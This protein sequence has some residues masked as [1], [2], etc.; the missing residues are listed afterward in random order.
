MTS[1]P[2]PIAKAHL[3]GLTPP[4]LAA[5]C[6][7]VLLEPRLARR[8]L[9]RVVGSYRDTLDG[10]P[11]LSKPVVAALE[12]HTRL[13]RL[14]L[15][16]VRASA[17]DPFAKFLFEAEDG[18][19]FEAVRI[20]LERP[21]WSVCVS[22]Q[23]G[24]ALGCRFCATGRLGLTRDLE[25]WEMVEQVLAVRA[26]SP[27]RPVTGVVFQGQGEPLL[28]YDRVL[29]A[30]D[31]LREP[32]GGRIGS[33]RISLSTVGLPA[34]IA[35]YTDEGHPYRLILS[36]T[37]TRDDRR[38][39]LIPTARAHSVS[40]IAQAMRRH[41]RRVRG[42]VHLAWVLI[43]GLNTGPEEAQG[44]AQL[45]PDVPLRVSLIDVNDTSGTYRP[46]EAREL[47]GFVDALAARGIAFVRRYSGGPDILAACGTLASTACGGRALSTA[48][49]PPGCE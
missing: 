48:L 42:V 15:V 20:P 39:L 41:A 40:D 38:A 16:D 47:Q 26:A 35:R 34:Q 37:S 9:S 33:D 22:S 45:F 46:P 6:P 12:R 23:A 7:D 14:Q 25:A 5:L 3:R 11:G 31:V 28:N 17:V 2:A 1:Q 13:S 30:I 44:L 32:C 18:V 4:A 8:I 43:R 29:A 21:R 10:I 24:C 36:L 19:R 49:T 27:E